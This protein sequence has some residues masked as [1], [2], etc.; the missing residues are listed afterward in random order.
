MRGHAHEKRK[1]KFFRFLSCVCI[2]AMNA[3]D[4][5]FIISESITF[6]ALAGHKNLI[7]LFK[8]LWLVVGINVPAFISNWVFRLS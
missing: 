3:F 1:K 5:T 7:T 6:K 8:I 4:G 2:K